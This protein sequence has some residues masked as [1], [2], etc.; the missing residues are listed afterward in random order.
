MITKKHK[1]E[2]LLEVDN[3]HSASCGTPPTLDAS[4]KYLGYF[5]NQHGEQWAF[6]GDRKTGNAVLRGGDVGW[7]KEYQL[8]L[9]HPCPDAILNQ[10]EQ[11]WL[12]TCFMAPVQ[13]ALRRGRGQ[14]QQGGE[15]P[16]GGHAEEA[17]RAGARRP[18]LARL[19]EALAQTRSPR[20]CGPAA[21]ER[22]LGRTDQFLDSYRGG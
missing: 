22:L 3:V 14:L 13:Q 17:G 8:S 6:V 16:G 15:A 1:G 4:D 7:K 21:A 2:R 11:V 5:E 9:T 18:W 19:G 20:W 10:P 12:I